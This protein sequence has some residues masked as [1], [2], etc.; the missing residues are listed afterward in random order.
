MPNRLVG[1]PTSR[2][3]CCSLTNPQSTTH[4][5]SQLL[6]SAWFVLFT[7]ALEPEWLLSWYVVDDFPTNQILLIRPSFSWSTELSFMPVFTFF[8]T[9]LLYLCLMEN[10]AVQSEST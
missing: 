1:G 7:A 8:I 3:R 6:V 2:N 5:L 9:V 10:L 4:F